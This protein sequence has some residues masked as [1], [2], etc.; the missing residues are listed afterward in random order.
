ME[1]WVGGSACG[2]LSRWNVGGWRQER[3]R[4]GG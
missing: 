2:D 4:T 1:V 3:I